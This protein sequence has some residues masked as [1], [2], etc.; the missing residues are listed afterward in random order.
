MPTERH[1]SRE[2]TTTSAA[3][4][5]TRHYHHSNNNHKHDTRTGTTK[6]KTKTKTHDKTSSMTN[7]HT[8]HPQDVRRGED[9][10]TGSERLEH[11]CVESSRTQCAAHLTAPSSSPC[12]KSLTS[13][14][15]RSALPC[16]PNQNTLTWMHTWM[17]TRVHTEVYTC[18][19]ART[20][21]HA[22]VRTHRCT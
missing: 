6:T 22:H 11:T 3:T 10:D 12:P 18:T 9:M 5:M 21:P 13:Y 8:A 19:C 20:R 1:H 17:H 16:S 4:A 7:T 14:C 2:T 15:P